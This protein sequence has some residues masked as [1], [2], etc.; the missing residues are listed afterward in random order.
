MRFA[1]I[2]NKELGTLNL[3]GGE[4]LL[5]PKIIDFM[6]IAR[7]NLPN[8][9]IQIVTN[10]IL[11]NEQKEDFWHACNKYDIKIVVTKYPIKLDFEK[12]KNTAKNIM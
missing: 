6:R 2:S 4:P 7:E 12:I 3:L 10:G 5:N 8:T 9:N 11:L 1:Q